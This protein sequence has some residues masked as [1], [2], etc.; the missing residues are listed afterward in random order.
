MA[1]DDPKP[2]QVDFSI[3]QAAIARALAKERESKA[4]TGEPAPDADL[5]S[6]RQAVDRVLGS[7]VPQA[8]PPPTAPSAAAARPPEPVRP[9]ET[10]RPVDPV[11]PPRVPPAEPPQ[12]ASQGPTIASRDFIQRL[13]EEER[14]RRAM[15]ANGPGEVVDLRGVRPV[16]GKPADPGPVQPQPRI[17]PAVPEPGPADRP[18]PVPQPAEP[19]A[20]VPEAAGPSPVPPDPVAAMGPSLAAPEPSLGEALRTVSSALR[21]ETAAKVRAVGTRVAGGASSLRSGLTGRARPAARPE[22]RVEVARP[23]PTP[24]VRPRR[25]QAP[26]TLVI[27]RGWRLFIIALLFLGVGAGS[28]LVAVWLA[29]RDLPLADILPQVEAPSLL[30][31]TVDGQILTTQGAYRAPYVTLDRMPPALIDAVVS[32]EDR[33]FREHGGVDWRGVG[34]ALFR[35]V[36]A[37]GVVEGGSTITQQ[38]V[39]I[40]YLEPERTLGRKLQ[41]AVLATTLERQ[42]GKDRILELYLNS[43]YLGSGAYGMP[44]AA[45]TYF[46]KTVSD[47]TL[48]EAATLAAS[49]QLPSQ[50]NPVADLG[51]VQNRAALVLTLMEQQGRIDTETRDRALIDLA[52]LSPDPPSTRAGSYFADWVLKQLE[53]LQGARSQEL[54]ATATL[55]P[56]LQAQAEA[57]VRDVITREGAA[58]GASQA[59]LVAMTP[60]GRVRAMVGGIDYRQSQFNRAADARRQPGSTFKLFVY[61]AALIKGETPDSPISDEPLEIDGWAPENFDER[62]HGTVTLREAFVQ[63][64]NLAAVRL[65]QQLGLPDVVEV[66]RRFG[67]EGRLAERPSLALGTSETTLLDMTEAY[68]AVALGRAPVRATGIESLSFGGERSALGVTGTND[69]EQT[70][71]T[72]TR[73]PIL[74]MLR[75][76]VANGTG[77]A[78]AV[79][80]LRVAGKTG[81]SQDNR[82]AWFIGFADGLVIGVWVGNDDNSP[83]DRVTGGGLP[84]EIF[85]RTMIAA[86]GEQAAADAPAPEPAAA[87]ARAPQCDIRACSAAYQSFRAEDCTYQPLEGP[88]QICTR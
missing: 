55:D 58:A 20:A 63:S 9:A 50:I 4:A 47:L 65:A 54:A 69:R 29:M 61:M 40:L 67:I 28:S 37:G 80:G 86:K 27:R 64:Y 2:G 21:R 66:A 88:R 39:K 49:I 41:E 31:R 12:S 57:I 34:R 84:A 24:V 14:R 81:T 87:P 45:Q 53:A 76:V 8:A 78:A 56:E 16:E 74:S 59:A 13:R 42:L 82:D 79:P 22:P 46:D 7:P 10:P 15:S 68:A 73:N 1:S 30:V 19:E 32:I 17:Q 11:S 52:A 62:S 36:T 60:N 26:G 75:D 72:R 23:T 44:A 77:R 3:L 51:A 48:P 85:R 6:M 25:S 35:N 43:V 71:L 38:L 18:E 33:R 70:R 83:M 5:S